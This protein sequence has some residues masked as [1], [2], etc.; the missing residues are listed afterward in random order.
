MYL[1]K[2]Y[3]HIYRARVQSRHPR[4]YLHTAAMKLAWESGDIYSATQLPVVNYSVPAGL[5]REIGLM[6]R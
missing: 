1:E 3:L 5:I 4:V 2:Q 6:F